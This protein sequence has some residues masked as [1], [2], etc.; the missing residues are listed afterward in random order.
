MLLCI[1]E[2]GNTNDLIAL[3]LV[4]IPNNEIEKLSQ[5]FTIRETDPNEI[6]TLYNRIPKDSKKPRGEFKY[7][8]LRNA[9]NATGLAVY[10]EFLKSKLNEIGKTN[11]QAYFSIF[12]KPKENS[13]RRE[14]LKIEAQML[15]AT[16]AKNNSKIAL[17]K[18][19]QI[20]VDQQV[21]DKEYVFQTYER[22]NKRYYEIF[23][24]HIITG[25]V[26]Y[27]GQENQVQITER[28]SKTFKPL[29]ISD[30]LVGAFRESRKYKNCEFF[31]LIKQITKKEWI[32][33]TQGE[34][35]MPPEVKPIP[36]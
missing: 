14:I 8:D 5:L 32:R 29:Q 15:I 19:L 1:D 6:I 20:V 18:E 35:K 27:G 11:S 33:E 12:N 24:K 22:R 25:T 26:H 4:A 16:W 23:P 31:D 34:Y 36:K 21:F 2:S 17:S 30:F 3:G 13:W 10:K 7:S 9:E 28:N